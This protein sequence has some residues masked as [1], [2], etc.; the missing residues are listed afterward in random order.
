[1]SSTLWLLVA[2]FV[3]GL[4]NIGIGIWLERKKRR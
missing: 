1:M 4:V 2:A 3:V